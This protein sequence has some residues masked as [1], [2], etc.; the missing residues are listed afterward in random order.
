VLGVRAPLNSETARFMDRMAAKFD[1]LHPDRWAATLPAATGQQRSR[2]SAAACR[3]RLWP[4]HAGLLAAGPLP[5]PP[6]LARRPGP[7]P[8]PAPPAAWAWPL[9]LTIPP[10]PIPGRLRIRD[11]ARRRPGDAGYEPR[12]VHVPP[13]WFK[14]H[15]VSDGQRQWW[16]FKALN[17]DSVLLFKMGKFYEV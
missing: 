13:E 11:A 8:Q 6:C 15:S 17:F 12:S 2:T 1:F 3:Q 10:A 16:Q 7:E 14:K 9:P 5:S 4:H